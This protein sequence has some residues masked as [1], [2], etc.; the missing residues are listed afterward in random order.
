M[1]DEEEDQHDLFEF[2]N[3]YPLNDH[4]FSKL[5]SNV[6]IWEQLALDNGDINTIVPPNNAL[7]Q[8][9]FL[10]LPTQNTSIDHKSPLHPP[11]MYMAQWST[12]NNHM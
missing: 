10:I 2:P 9:D 1:L 7:L 12:I 4:P 3:G 8:I 5:L 6:R 11:W